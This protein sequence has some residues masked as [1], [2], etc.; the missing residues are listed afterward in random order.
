MALKATKSS[1]MQ[2]KSVY[3]A[4]QR[5][6]TALKYLCYYI[7]RTI[8]FEHLLNS[9]TITLPNIVKSTLQSR[10]NLRQNQHH[11]PSL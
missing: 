2:T 3:A 4:S 11:T 8:L 5:N 9:F 7:F 1:Y 6:H 10:W